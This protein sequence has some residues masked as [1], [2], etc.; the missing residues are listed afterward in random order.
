MTEELIRYARPR[1]EPLWAAQP[2]LSPETLESLAEVNT[3]CLEL[4]CEEASADAP[5]P[6]LRELRPLLRGLDAHARGRAARCPCLLVDA[7]FMEVRRWG[8][9]QLAQIQDSEAPARPFFTS[10]RAVAVMRLVVTYAWH[11]SRSQ[12]AA[13]RLLCGLS[14]RCGELL[15]ACSLGHVTR[16]AE[17]HPQWLR[18]RWSDRSSVWADLLRAA[19]SGEAAALERIGFRGVQ[20]L[21]AQVRT[22]SGGAD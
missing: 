11:L 6:L 17:L 5:A 12:G 10:V 4:L 15:G 7:G 21:A 14:M 8:P 3:E 18:P 9:A 16:L 22:E 20:L 1:R 2:C 13:A 19:S